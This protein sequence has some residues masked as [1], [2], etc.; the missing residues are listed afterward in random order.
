MENLIVPD[1]V[2]TR[3]HQFLENP[4]HLSL[5]EISASITDVDLKE[6]LR[7]NNVATENHG[8]FCGD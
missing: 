1:D 2:R 5:Q 7:L 3:A 4:T 8:K 6:L